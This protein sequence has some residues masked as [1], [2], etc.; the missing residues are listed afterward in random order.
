MS[1]AWM[2]ALVPLGRSQL[3]QEDQQWRATKLFQSF[4]GHENRKTYLGSHSWVMGHG[5][6]SYH[7]HS[8]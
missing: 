8:I 7:I 5:W 1:P 4:D 2:V 6:I 3:K